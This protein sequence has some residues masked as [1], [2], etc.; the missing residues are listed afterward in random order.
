MTNR[1]DKDEEP[2]GAGSRPLDA[3]PGPPGCHLAS[4]PHREADPEAHG[5]SLQ[6]ALPAGISLHRRTFQPWHQSV[7]KA[8][9]ILV[10]DSDKVCHAHKWALQCLLQDATG[11]SVSGNAGSIGRARARVQHQPGGIP[12]AAVYNHRLARREAHAGNT[13][14][15]QRDPQ[16]TCAFWSS[17][18]TTQPS[19]LPHQPHSRTKNASKPTEMTVQC[20]YGPK[21]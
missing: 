16:T 9:L 1:A 20:G 2:L 14:D 19:L 6:R 4:T 10:L 17:H 15:R 7:L 18:I 12:P 5:Q 13:Q 8:N 3:C 21:A 11:I